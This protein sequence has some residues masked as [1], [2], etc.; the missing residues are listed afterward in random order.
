[1]NTA[2]L[3]LAALAC[4]ASAAAEPG[5]R[6]GGFEDGLDGWK[7]RVSRNMGEVLLADDGA[8][9][10]CVQF[11]KTVATPDYSCIGVTQDVAVDANSEYLVSL[12]FRTAL[13]EGI[14]GYACRVFASGKGVDDHRTMSPSKEWAPF[15]WQFSTGKETDKITLQLVLTYSSGDLWIDDVVLRKVGGSIEAEEF[16]ETTDASPIGDEGLGGKGGVEL[17]AEGAIRTALATDAG[18]WRIEVF[19]EG[20]EA[21]E[22]L[23]RRAV[24]VQLDTRS[25]T[26]DL[27]KH[28]TK[29]HGRV[30]YL[31]TDQSREHDLVVR[32]AADFK[33]RLVID[34]V[35]WVAYSGPDQGTAALPRDA[36]CQRRQAYGRDRHRPRRSDADG[37]PPSSVGPAREVWCPTAAGRSPAVDVGRSPVSACRRRR[38]HA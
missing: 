23:T 29:Y 12:R 33:G 19:G 14:V 21:E 31:R 13:K 26:V 5:L 6:N 1:M 16:T 11:H 8:G 17:R 25:Q 27:H 10:K 3:S 32:R 34:R 22:E 15:E 35:S 2:L 4:C 20:A 9:G 38:Q 36:T 28:G 24:T 30:A 7:P 18:V 37:G